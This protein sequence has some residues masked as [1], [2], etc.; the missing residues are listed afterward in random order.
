MGPIKGYQPKRNEDAEF[1]AGL[2]GQGEPPE[3]VKA[4]LVERG[5]TP[6]AADGLISQLY[7]NWV[8]DDAARMLES[9]MTPAA[10]KEALAA[11]G[12]SPENANTVVDNIAA[13]RGLAHGEASSGVGSVRQV[14]GGIVIVI[15]VVL[16][17]G[18]W[19]GL[20]RTFPFAGW[21]TI[22][23]GGAIAGSKS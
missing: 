3:G 23:I 18:N 22:F 7:A 21:I 4:K 12:L 16:L 19:T 13:Q 1:A 8:Y 5:M 10:V 17:L 2:L 9:G 11:K 14:V 20:L 6:D 15:G